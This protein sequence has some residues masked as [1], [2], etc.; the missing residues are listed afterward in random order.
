MNGANST[1]VQGALEVDELVAK[2]EITV[3]DPMWAQFLS[4]QSFCGYKDWQANVAKN[5]TGRTCGDTP[6]LK[7]GS[8]RYNLYQL[9]S[10]GTLFVGKLAAPYDGGSPDTRARMLDTSRPFKKVTKKN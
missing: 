5:V 8:I 9:M 3:R 7:A 10:D 1:K 4:E 6:V 2:V